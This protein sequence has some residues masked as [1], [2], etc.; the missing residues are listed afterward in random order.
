[1]TRQEFARLRERLRAEIEGSANASFR[2]ARDQWARL[3]RREAFQ[4]A[5]QRRR[6]TSRKI[7]LGGLVLK[8][9]L[10]DEDPAVI[11]GLLIE[12]ARVLRSQHGHLLRARLKEAGDNALADEQMEI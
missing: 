1:M 4:R 10:G 3:E 6:N 9:G 12:T 8:A 5:M 7:E 11:L 2:E